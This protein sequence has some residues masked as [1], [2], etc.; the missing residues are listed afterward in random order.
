MTISRHVLHALPALPL[1]MG[2]L[3]VMQW[4]FGFL[5]GNSCRVRIPVLLSVD[6]RYD[7]RLDDCLDDLLD[8]LRLDMI[9]F[10]CKD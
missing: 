1:G 3:Q 9:S 2:V 4:L 10:Q 6:V 8:G 5:C 7:L